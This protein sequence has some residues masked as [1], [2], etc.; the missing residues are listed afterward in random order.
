MTPFHAACFIKY[1]QQRKCVVFEITGRQRSSDSIAVCRLLNKSTHHCADVLFRANTRREGRIS[2][3]CRAT[4]NH[5]LLY[6]TDADDELLVGL[7]VIY[8]S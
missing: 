2:C 8:S 3:R 7:H 4:H 5:L 1:N 6:A